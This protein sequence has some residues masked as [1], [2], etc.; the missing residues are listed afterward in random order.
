MRAFMIFAALD[1]GLFGLGLLTI[2]AL[3]LAPYG[4]ELNTSGLMMCRLLGSALIGLAIVLWWARGEA[5][6]GVAGSLVLSNFV[7]NLID[8]AVLSVAMHR[9]ELGVLGWG[10]IGLHVVLTA[11]FGWLTLRRA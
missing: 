7:Y 10:P 6:K 11:G 8:V 9:G 2:P 3:F 5:L 1:Y 4:V